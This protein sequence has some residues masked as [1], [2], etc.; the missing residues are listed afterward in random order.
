[1]AQSWPTRLLSARKSQNSTETTVL[2][3]TENNM[4]YIN[5][6]S[7]VLRCAGAGS[8]GGGTISRPASSGSR[9]A[10]S[11]TTWERSRFREP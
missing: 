8:R 4:D 11:K 7:T 3:P 6:M 5:I 2:T 9:A 1:M 10:V